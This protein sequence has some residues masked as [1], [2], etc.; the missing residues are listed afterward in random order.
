M[1]RGLVGLIASLACLLILSAVVVAM[2][3]VMYSISYAPIHLARLFIALP[4]AAAGWLLLK[5]LD[6]R[7]EGGNK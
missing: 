6:R 1:N 4:L 2:M 3:A 5:W 7:I